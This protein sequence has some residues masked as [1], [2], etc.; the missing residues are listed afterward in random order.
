ML[1]DQV[2]LDLQAPGVG[3]WSVTLIRAPSSLMPVEMPLD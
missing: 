2:N 3:T 1:T